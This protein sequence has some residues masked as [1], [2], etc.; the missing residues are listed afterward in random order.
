MVACRTSIHR[1]IA[2]VG[3]GPFGLALAA[4]LQ[5]A[6]ADYILLGRLMS[7]W[8][9]HVPQGTCLLSDPLRCSLS[10]NGFD[11][12]AYERSRGSP[13]R[14]PFTAS[15]FLGYGLWFQHLTC[16][17]LDQRTVLSIKHENRKY[18]IRV[19]DGD[20][21]TA[22]NVVIAIGLRMF[23]VRPPEVAALPS[24]FF[25]HTSDLHDLSH[26]R[27]KKLA[28]VGN[29]QSALE[30]AALLTENNSDVEVLARSAHLVWRR[31]AGH[32]ELSS[33]E[34]HWNLRPAIRS[35]LNDPD[36]YRRLPCFVRDFW[37]HRTLRTAASSTLGS[38]LG[39]VRFTL[40]CRVTAARV[41]GDRV[42]LHL[43]DKSTRTVDHIVL[44][45]GYRVDINAVP[46][47]APEL[48]R[49]I[50]LHNGYPQLNS[51]MESTVAGLYFTGA[52]AAWNFGP[53]MWFV[54]RAPWAAERI[55]RAIQS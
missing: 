21:I 35:A 37:L 53:I 24:E 42:E 27:R 12:S 26:L 46:F 2:V 43:T 47:L 34:A 51:M 41:K 40:G 45:T 19:D 22:D 29:G 4:R 18:T 13:I 16:S 8:R 44:G 6:N 5:S 17:N 7:F 23:A 3:A 11:T 33:V 52:A 31:F 10:L 50:R 25:S 1:R 39:A 14:R 36:V 48:R 20:Q 54:H 28:I 15:E 49:Q 32:P 55:T 38:R 30:C 9:E